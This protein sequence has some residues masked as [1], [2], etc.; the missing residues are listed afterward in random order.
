LKTTKCL[1][2]ILSA[3]LVL[4]LPAWPQEA[5]DLKIVVLRGEGAQNS[6]KSRSATQPTIEVRGDGDKPIAGV[7][8]TFQMPFA[9]PGGAFNG[10]LNYEVVKT[11][12]EGRASATGMTPNDQ[13]GLFHIKVTATQGAK[14]A[15][16]VIAQTNVASTAAEKSPSHTKLYVILGLVAV[17]A[18]AGGVAAGHSG[19]GSSTP[20]ATNPVT[21]SSGPIT[22]GGPH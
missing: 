11:D 10:W 16:A 19:G 7:D 14:T 12:A 1:S 13:L 4:P 15:T 18:I 22:V 21:I 8:V 9:G 6:I 5:G 2:A 17:G 3:A 20:A